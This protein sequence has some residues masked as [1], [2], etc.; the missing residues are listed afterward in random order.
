MV[1]AWASANRLVFGPIKV[2]GKSNEITAIPA[3]LQLSEIS[4]CIVTID[5]MG[6]QKEIAARIHA[7]DGD[8]VLAVMDDQPQLRHACERPGTNASPAAPTGPTT[9]LPP[10]AG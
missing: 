5:A 4:D 9:G 10:V 8:Y 7:Q 3:L 6:C 1:S 2:D